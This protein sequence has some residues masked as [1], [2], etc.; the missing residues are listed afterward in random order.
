[1]KH[2]TRFNYFQQIPWG[3][4]RLVFGEM[5]PE[6]GA[7]Y[8][9]EWWILYPEDLGL[10]RIFHV[11]LYPISKANRPDNIYDEGSF[12][13]AEIFLP[14]YRDGHIITWKRSAPS[15]EDTQAIIDE[16][17]QF[18]NTFAFMAYGL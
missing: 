9:E 8:N 13:G 11:D 10:D 16:T 2:F 5:Y 6:I 4:M 1:M 15:T 12:S 14:R 3:N 18:R 7:N 17:D